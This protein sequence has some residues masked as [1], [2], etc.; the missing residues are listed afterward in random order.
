MRTAVSG[1][2]SLSWLGLW[3]TW[4]ALTV[5]TRW[6]SLILLAI[7]G[8]GLVG[9]VLL[10]RPSNPWAWMAAL[11]LALGTTLAARADHALR[12][13]VEDWES[14]WQAREAVLEMEIDH[15]LSA[16]IE[17]GI[18]A[19]QAA[20]RIAAAGALD[21]SAVPLGDILREFGVDAVAV[22]GPDGVPLAWE[23]IHR[24]SVPRT[25]RMGLSEYL[26]WDGPLFGYLYFTAQAPQMGGTAAAVSLLRADMPTELGSELGD[27]AHRF[28]SETGEVIRISRAEWAEG[29][30]I[31]DLVWED[32]A[33]F[34]V[35][36]VQ[37]RQADR[38]AE[39]RGRWG[40]RIS[41]LLVAAWVLMLLAGRPVLWNPVA[42]GA[43]LLFGAGIL[44]LGSVVG[45]E[46]LFSPADFLLP[47]PLALTLGRVLAV[48][49][50]ATVALSFMPLWRVH[51]GGLLG[52]ALPVASG[53][54][55]VVALFGSGYTME[56]L[57]GTE[58]QWIVFQGTLALVLTLL[59][60]AG[61]LL[62]S[63]RMEGKRPAW[64]YPAALGVAAFL[65]VGCFFYL[66]HETDLPVWVAAL[67]SVPALM[68]V[69]CLSPHRGWKRPALA[70][71]AAIVLG[72][73]ASLPYSWESRLDARM[74][75]AEE[76]LRG[77]GGTVDPYLQF[78]L[79]RLG[80]TV[81]S[82][83]TLGASPVE[84]LFG[85]WVAS[86][87]AGESYPVWL[88]LWSEEGLA[89]R[90]LDI[91]VEQERPGIAAEIRDEARATGLSFARLAGL[92]D[93]AYVA[94]TPLGGGGVIT[95]VI[96]P[97]RELAVASPLGPLFSSVRAPGGPLTLFRLSA[98]ETQGGDGSARW[99]RTDAG[100]QGELVVEYPEGPYRANYVLG[101][102][103]P[104]VLTA[105]ATLLLFLEC[106]VFFSV[107]A[108]GRALA[109]GR[110]TDPGRLLGLVSS[111]RARV[112]LA[113]F[114]FFLLPLLAFGT[115]AYRTLE[116][117]RTARALAERAVE[118]AAE[119]YPE[120][121]GDMEVL[122]RRV[123]TD[124]LVYDRG[125]LVGGSIGELLELGLYEGWVPIS[126]YRTLEKKAE[127]VAA[128]PGSLGTWEYVSAYS[129][130]PNRLVLASITPLR[131]GATALRQQDVADLLGFGLVVGAVFS[132]GLALLVGRALARPIQILQVASE[133]VGAGNLDLHLPEERADEFGS[134]FSAFNRMVSRLDD[135]REALI[136]SNRQTR[137]I[138]AEA[139]I[140]VIALSPDGIVTLINPRAESLL[141]VGVAMGQLL[142]AGEGYL[143]E[144]FGWVDRY[145]REGLE[146]ANTEQEFGHRR[147]R[148]RARRIP[149]I[150][151]QGGAVII[152]ED[153]TD[154]LRS[155]RILAWG[156]MARQVAHEVK[157]PLTPIRLSIQHIQRA[158][159]DRRPDF[160]EILPRN[161]KAILREIER[162]ETIA[163]SFSSIAGPRAAGEIPLQEVHIRDAALDTLELY[164]P[165]E[166]EIRFDCVVPEG[167]PAVQARDAELK[168]VLVNLLE[169]SRAAVRGQ[170]VVTVDARELSGEV[171]LIVADD[172]AGIPEDLLP[173]VFEPHFSTHS[174][175]AG[176]G[177]AIVRR[178]VESWGGHVAA[179]NRDGGGALIRIRLQPWVT[180][181]A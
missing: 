29:E 99:E 7:A 45:L 125:E 154:E 178:L 79:T 96:P 108:F 20:A 41:L 4:C 158:W 179:E 139:A 161:A 135:A 159:E 75:L 124:L 44:P 54:V 165:G 171:E 169:N 138:L 107:W 65:S 60:D 177:L 140:G 73:T 170:G 34:S 91:G 82:L 38:L 9:W 69:P 117:G 127:R 19:A 49:L 67:W 10:R 120:V 27:F 62:G 95:A 134:V 88:T 102:R 92:E 18:G 5:W 118:D 115:L 52:T 143:G 89:L 106:L 90:E 173:R 180:G 76:E 55:T 37:P 48:G 63:S 105:R 133:R 129:V 43:S 8:A 155:E 172:G 86:G 77:L 64:L 162:L 53:F 72:T 144:F 137:T 112:T 2:G 1:A 94:A 15:R 176:L 23:G 146:E 100:W 97:R 36:V 101:V 11:A 121:Q 51:L 33:L 80:E 136:R 113:L 16:L 26:Y 148:V 156:E 131:V 181:S 68:A 31:L 160:D 164:Q 109:W 21:E 123:G 130:L 132:L 78:L 3:V 114:G 24:G 150:G 147:I 83:E 163:G 25:V 50:A 39:T 59:A 12:R 122:A 81:D 110:T 98:E 153:V 47:G 157:N 85:G 126:A 13:M 103:P 22:Y 6:T 57:A 119:W 66:A 40:R 116:A 166:G 151:A 56:F 14:V 32:R 17:N 74:A 30:G 168:E 58:R 152:L 111:F 141:G 42:A 93:A 84:M 142:P 61:L 71:G 87:L 70:W 28:M 46:H 175:G 167:L 145:L 128:S 35:S 149:R 174:S 104:V